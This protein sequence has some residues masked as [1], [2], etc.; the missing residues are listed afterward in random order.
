MPRENSRIIRRAFHTWWR[1]ERD[2]QSS[3]TAKHNFYLI[4]ICL[5]YKLYVHKHLATSRQAKCYF[6]MDTHHQGPWF[7]YG[8]VLRGIII[9]SFR[10]SF[11]GETRMIGQSHYVDFNVKHHVNRFCLL[12]I[13]VYQTVYVIIP[14][15]LFFLCRFNE[16]YGSLGL[17]DYLHSTDLS[18]R[19]RSN[20]KRHVIL[21]GRDSARELYPDI[22][23]KAEQ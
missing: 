10:G 15:A 4:I 3:S 1:I 13:V 12:S 18:F 20:Y 23:K 9:E 7:S 2:S 21:T 6:Q 16:C 5:S 19:K 17:L 11:K 14:A 8:G 22:K